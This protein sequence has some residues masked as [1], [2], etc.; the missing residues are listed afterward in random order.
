MPLP[1][2]E[3]F[4]RPLLEVVSDG[5]DHSVREVYVQAAERLARKSP[6]CP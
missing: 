2:Y 5:Q 1:G 4:M 3:E 6:E